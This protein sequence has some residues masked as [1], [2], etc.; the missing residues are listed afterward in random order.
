MG[1]SSPG[2]KTDASKQPFEKPKPDPSKPSRALLA[3]LRPKGK[4]VKLY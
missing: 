4:K 1:M 2:T 3:V